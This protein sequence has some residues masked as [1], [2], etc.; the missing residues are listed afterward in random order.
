MKGFNVKNTCLITILLL[1][2]SR[3]YVFSTGIGGVGGIQVINLNNGKIWSSISTDPMA[4][5]K[6]INKPEA[7]KYKLSLSYVGKKSVNNNYKLGGGTI[8]QE[9]NIAKEL[10]GL[11]CK[12]GHIF[13]KPDG[14]L[15]DTTDAFLAG[16]AVSVS[17][18][19]VIKYSA[20]I[21]INTDQLSSKFTFALEGGVG[22]GAN[23]V[24]FSYGEK[25]DNFSLFDFFDSVRK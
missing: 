6:N 8:S 22:L 3:L 18:G 14:K 5:A 19:R 15:A 10:G 23:G 13:N 1:L 17:G 12:A 25:S 7:Y 16:L 2:I 20:T 4:V 9:K 21:P 24:D 11:G